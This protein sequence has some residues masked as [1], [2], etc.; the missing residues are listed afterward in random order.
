MNK[1]T[2]KATRSDHYKKAS[3]GAEECNTAT[4][5]S[6]QRWE[7]WWRRRGRAS[8]TATTSRAC[9]SAIIT[10]LPSARLRASMAATAGASAAAASA[11][12]TASFEL[13]P[14]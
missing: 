4:S 1:K 12:S 8:R 14:P 5:F 10:A 3:I 7:G 2:L 11:P 9:A 6:F 13:L